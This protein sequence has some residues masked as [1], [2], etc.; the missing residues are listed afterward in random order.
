MYEKK[1]RPKQDNQ[2]STNAC[3]SLSSLKEKKK[4]RVNF[5]DSCQAVE[6]P[7]KDG[8][9]IRLIPYDAYH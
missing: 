5:S 1:H 4:Q 3:I 9:Q 2:P 7:F 8:G 6:S